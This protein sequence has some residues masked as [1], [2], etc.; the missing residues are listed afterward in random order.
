MAT[1]PA[2]GGLLVLFTAMIVVL[3]FVGL[4]MYYVSRAYRRRKG[5]DLDLAYKEIPPE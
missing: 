2:A 4:I 5:M 1:M 3:Y